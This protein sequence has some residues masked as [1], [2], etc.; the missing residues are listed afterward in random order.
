MLHLYPVYLLCNRRKTLT[1]SPD[2]THANS[3]NKPCIWLYCNNSVDLLGYFVVS[4][5][6]KI[7]NACSHLL[8]EL[9]CVLSQSATGVRKVIPFYVT[10]SSLPSSSLVLFFG[11][12]WL[13][14]IYSKLRIFLFRLSLNMS[15]NHLII[16]IH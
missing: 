10:N 8:L 9:I 15:I 11:N 14:S 3:T 12:R 6:Q 13:K 5:L 4:M 16:V 7:R 1:G 2:P